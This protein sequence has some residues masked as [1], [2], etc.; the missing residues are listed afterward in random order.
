M[1]S[2]HSSNSNIAVPAVAYT[3]P[4]HFAPCTYESLHIRTCLQTTAR[5]SLQTVNI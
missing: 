5:N 4:L 3:Q 2:T 1:N